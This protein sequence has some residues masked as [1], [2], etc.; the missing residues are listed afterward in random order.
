M[1]KIDNSRIEIKGN[2]KAMSAGSARRTWLRTVVMVLAGA[3]A[4]FTCYQMINDRITVDS[5]A[6]IIA[7]CIIAIMV[8][9]AFID[10][11]GL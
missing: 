1:Q 2:A 11:L 3:G 6:F 8:G 10:R 7:G 9:T 4:V 5:A